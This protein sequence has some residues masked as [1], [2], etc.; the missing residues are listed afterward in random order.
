L[1][2]LILIREKGSTSI[3]EIADNLGVG[4]SSVSI[5]VDR[6]VEAGILTREQNPSDRR[7]VIVRVAADVEKTIKPIERQAL[8][9]LV[10]LLDTLGPET[11]RTWRE[12][13]ARIREILRA[14]EPKA[15]PCNPT[16]NEA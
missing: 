13:N 1:T 9:T 14:P 16:R 8:G 7:G 10:D 15:P 12:I 4:T 2:L 5:M 6:L 11:A 3:K